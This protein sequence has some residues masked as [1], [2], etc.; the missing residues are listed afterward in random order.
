[1]IYIYLHLVDFMVHVGKYTIHGCY[2]FGWLQ[3]PNCNLALLWSVDYWFSHDFVQ[4]PTFPQILQG[5][6]CICV[7]PWNP[8]QCYFTCIEITAFWLHYLS[9]EL[10]TQ[11]QLQFCKT[12]P[13]NSAQ[14]QHTPPKI[15]RMSK[16]CSWWFLCPD[17]FPHPK[18]PPGVSSRW[19]WLKNSRT[20]KM[21][22]NHIVYYIYIYINVCILYIYIF[23][24]KYNKY[25]WSPSVFFWV[26]TQPISSKMHAYVRAPF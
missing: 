9:T 10:P 24:K 12:S 11:H 4:F 15:K 20:G 1:M 21:Y 25:D 8:F 2:G 14:V 7:S 17:G 22:A 5:I 23:Q 16:D 26:K 13:K 19:N 18:L 3:I 6:K